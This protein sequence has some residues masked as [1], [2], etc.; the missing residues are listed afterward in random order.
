MSPDLIAVGDVEHS[1]TFYFRAPSGAGIPLLTPTLQGV[2]MNGVDSNGNLVKRTCTGVITIP[3]QSVL[4]NQGQMVLAPSAADV[5]TAGRYTLEPYVTVNGLLLVG[6][7][8]QITIR[9]R[10]PA[11]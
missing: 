8:Q 10:V 9:A 4:A 6:P 7:R 3:D 11:V 1:W 5:G 2:T